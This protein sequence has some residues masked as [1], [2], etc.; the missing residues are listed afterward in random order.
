MYVCVINARVSGHAGSILSNLVG[1]ERRLPGNG[2]IVHVHA[3][4]HLPRAYI[5]TYDI[6]E[7][8]CCIRVNGSQLKE[9]KTQQ[10]SS[11]RLGMFQHQ[12]SSSAKEMKTFEVKTS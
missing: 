10:E 3:C 2:L 8:H 1:A 5:Y 11:K 6:V 9:Q 12:R 4:F 7:T